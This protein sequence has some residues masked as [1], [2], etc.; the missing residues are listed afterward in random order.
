MKNQQQEL[1]LPAS[2]PR[3]CLTLDPRDNCLLN[4][5][6]LLAEQRSSLLSKMTSN[7]PPRKV[8][9]SEPKLKRNQENHQSLVLHFESATEEAIDR[10]LQMVLDKGKKT[11]DWM[12]DNALYTEGFVQKH[13][14]A[15]P[16]VVL[17]RSYIEGQA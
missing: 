8:N 14:K 9:S 7:R 15:S 4:Q 10:L 1:P 17:L 12:Q 13:F 6:P 5:L 3:E 2:N 16:V 11:Q